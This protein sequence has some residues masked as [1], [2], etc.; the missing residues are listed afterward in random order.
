[1]FPK[2]FNNGWLKCFSYFTYASEK[3]PYD[4]MLMWVK[5]PLCLIKHHAMKTYGEMEI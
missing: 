4:E 1:M 3:L 2:V 5:L